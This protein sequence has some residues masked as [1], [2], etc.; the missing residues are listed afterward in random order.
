L[1][2]NVELDIKDGRVKFILETLVIVALVAS[3]EFNVDNPVIVDVIS[4]S[5]VVEI[6]AKL[7]TS[8]LE[9]NISNIDD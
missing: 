6:P 7:D 5:V 9:P 8:V 1:L 4:D 2:D 3:A